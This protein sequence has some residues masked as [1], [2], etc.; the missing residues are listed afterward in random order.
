MTDSCYIVIKCPAIGGAWLPC[1]NPLCT[2]CGQPWWMDSSGLIL[3]STFS[4]ATKTTR[5]A[6]RKTRIAPAL[7][8]VH[9][10]HADRSIVGLKLLDVTRVEALSSTSLLAFQKRPGLSSKVLVCVHRVPFR[11]TIFQTIFQLQFWITIWVLEACYRGSW[12]VDDE[13]KRWRR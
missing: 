2:R 7:D 11:H 10:V 8:M 9:A 3:L 13:F 5:A 12:R 1:A 4:S 6:R